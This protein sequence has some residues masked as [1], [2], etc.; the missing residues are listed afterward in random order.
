MCKRC[1]STNARSTLI[2]FSHPPECRTPPLPHCRSDPHSLISSLI[3][4]T[5][6]THLLTPSQNALQENILQAT[7]ALPTP[8]QK[9]FVGTASQ[10][11]EESQ[12]RE[13]S[14]TVEKSQTGEESQTGRKVRLRRKVGLGEKP[15]WEESQTGRKA[16]LGGKSDWEKSQTGE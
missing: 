8:Q 2:A 5:I 10:T 1:M 11:E 15:D 14:K 3:I 4:A 7:L 6:Q 16:G 12:T 9:S 13:E